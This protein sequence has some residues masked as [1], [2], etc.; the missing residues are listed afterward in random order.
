[1]PLEASLDPD[2]KEGCVPSFVFLVRRA[3]TGR[4]TGWGT[5][6]ISCL[7]L[8]DPSHQARSIY[9]IKTCGVVGYNG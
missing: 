4:F 8:P 6:T 2:A 3:R 1:M 5:C 7:K 9:R